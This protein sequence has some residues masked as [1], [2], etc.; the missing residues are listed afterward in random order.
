MRHRHRIASM[1]TIN[2]PIPPPIG[3]GL[4]LSNSGLW[5][6][7]RCCGAL[8]LMLFQTPLWAVLPCRIEVVEKGSGWPVPMVQLR[9]VHGVRF[10]SDNAGCIA[11]DLPELIGRETWFD[12]VG[13]GYEVPADGF[14]NRG[15]RIR[16][17]SGETVRIEVVRTSLARRLGRLTGAGLFGESQKL[18]SELDWEESGV[19][20]SDSLQMARHG[21]R[22]FWAWGDTLLARYPLGIFHMT[23][24]TTALSPL[25]RFEPP[26]RMKLNYFRDGDGVVR[27]VAPMPGEGPTW[28]TGYV[29][30]PQAEGPPRLVASYMKIRPPMEAYE[31][32]LCVWNESLERFERHRVLW[33]QSTS[34]P[35]ATPM[36]EGHPVRWSDAEGK[37]WVLFGNPLPTLRCPATFEAW[38]NTNT[39]DV[40]TPP[41]SLRAATGGEQVV[42]HSGSI[43]WNPFRK[44]WVTV[45]MQNGGRPSAFGE[46][47]YAEA[48]SP[49]GP[50]G[51]AVKVLTHE[52]YTFY[53]PRIHAE[54]VPSDSSFLLFEGTFTATF[55]DRPTPVARHD[56]NQMLYR[57]DLEDPRLRPAHAP[58]P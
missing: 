45:F 20:G 43:A 8:I 9:T 50:W 23:S 46:L 35:T 55:A 32:G 27:G 5:R 7:L 30:L 42:L 29:S 41:S 11:F 10:A 53:N 25:T 4:A 36:P 15:V 37:D 31:R 39:W 48:L 16:P 6:F 14:G 17:K 24:A 18:G 3:A 21:D 47:W 40:L 54:W 28:L 1:K 26:I 52:N 49:M 2:Q 44:R 51:P 58:S 12:V 33:T 57:L 34:T 22:L 13:H 19:L 56:Y 38:Q